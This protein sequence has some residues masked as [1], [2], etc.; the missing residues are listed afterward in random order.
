MIDHSWGRDTRTGAHRSRR[1]W[2]GEVT[3]P[4]EAQPRKLRVVTLEDGQT[5]HSAF[6]P[7]ILER[8]DMKLYYYAGTDRL[9]VDLDAAGDVVGFDIDRASV[10]LDLSLEVEAFPVRSYT[11][12]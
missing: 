3:V 1:R 6:R 12:A 11:V 5:V 9:N 7:R 2:W 8:N 10:R 4:G